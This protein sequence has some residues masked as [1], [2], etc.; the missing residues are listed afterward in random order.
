VVDQHGQNPS[1]D[2]V[3]GRQQ[4]CLELA[5]QLSSE[6]SHNTHLLK[7]LV[8]QLT[9]SQDELQRI[10]AD[11]DRLKPLALREDEA[12]S[13]CQA[14]ANVQ[15][16]LATANARRRASA[17]AQPTA[18][19]ARKVGKEMNCENRRLRDL[20]A[21]LAKKAEDLAYRLRC[22][23]KREGCLERRLDAV[24]ARN[25]QLSD[26]L[27]CALAFGRDQE[28]RLKATVKYQAQKIE[29]LTARSFKL[30]SA[31]PLPG[32]SKEDQENS[33]DGSNDAYDPYV[34]TVQSYSTLPS[35]RSS[36][37]SPPA[38]TGPNSQVPSC[39]AT[40][41]LFPPDDESKCQAELSAEDKQS[42]VLQQRP[43]SAEHRSATSSPLRPRSSIGIRTGVQNLNPTRCTSPGR[44]APL[45][46]RSGSPIHEHWRSSDGVGDCG[47]KDTLLCGAYAHPVDS[48]EATIFRN[49]LLIDRLHRPSGWIHTGNG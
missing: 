8:K 15:Q 26:Q 47:I 28:R 3:A 4:H 42:S 36:V 49:Q 23:Q 7:L 9:D 6:R 43:A 29:M 11:R 33:Y 31:D 32:V 1:F 41:W 38:G 20:A 16:Q 44:R 24:R 30:L 27:Q 17:P 40:L 18:A 10:K 25:R 13:D 34:T 45:S 12:I 19:F 46:A 37:V 35:P 22:S 5:L 14:L 39:I 2:E 21:G 48:L